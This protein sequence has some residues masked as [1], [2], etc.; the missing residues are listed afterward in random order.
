MVTPRPLAEKTLQEVVSSIKPGL[1]A[2]KINTL[3]DRGEISIKGWKA[4][5]NHNL[6]RAVFEDEGFV[7]KVRDYFRKE[8]G[9]YSKKKE[10]Y[11]EFERRLDAY[12]REKEK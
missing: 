11:Q 8:T 6:F 2:N 7:A 4:Q 10:A 5:D 9:S 1:L 3:Y 12:N